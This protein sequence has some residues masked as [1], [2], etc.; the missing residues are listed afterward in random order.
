M[1]LAQAIAQK[2]LADFLLWQRCSMPTGIPWG[3]GRSLLL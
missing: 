1:S 3:K 2:A